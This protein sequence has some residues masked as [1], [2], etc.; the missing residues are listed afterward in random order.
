[1]N[2][3]QDAEIQ[4]SGYSVYDCQ[5]FH[6][7]YFAFPLLC[8]KMDSSLLNKCGLHQKHTELPYK[9]PAI[10]SGT[11]ML[12]LIVFSTIMEYLSFALVKVK[13]FLQL[14]T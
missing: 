3:Q 12:V 6:L 14:I 9:S 13:S 10:V 2:V 4:Y 1:M 5:R 8:V 11:P 7:Q